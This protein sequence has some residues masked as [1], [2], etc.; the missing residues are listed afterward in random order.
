MRTTLNLPDRLVD[1]AKRKAL[2][3]H[4]T[5]TDLIAEGLENRIAGGKDKTLPVSGASGGLVPG[6]DW[7]R[8]EVAESPGDW[9]R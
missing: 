5:L 4:R 7:K 2:D 8:L 9:Y 6:L 1:R 3:E